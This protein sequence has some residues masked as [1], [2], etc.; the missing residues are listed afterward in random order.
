M[1]AAHAGR[2]HPDPAEPRG[3]VGRAGRGWRDGPRRPLGERRSHLARARV[4]EPARGEEAPRATGLRADRAAL[5]LP[6]VPGAGVDGPGSARRGEAQVL[7]LHPAP[8]IRSAGGARD[9][10]RSGA[11]RDRACA[12]RRPPDRGRAD[13]ALR[14]A[15]PRS[16][17]GHARRRRRAARRAGRR[18]GDVRRQPEHQLHERLRRRLRVLRLRPGPPLAGR[19]RGDR[20]RVP[21]P[22][23][24]S[25][26][27]RSNRDLHAGRH[28]PRLRACRLRP[29]ALA[30]QGSG[31]PAPPPRLLAH[32]GP[33][34]V[35]ALGPHARPGL[36]VSAS[37]RA[38]GPRRAPPPRSWTTG[39]G[40]ASRRTSCPSLAGSRSSRRRT[41]PACARPRP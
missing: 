34:H 3:L 26:R 29:V 11:R 35:R 18:H 4:P 30:R 2:R 36:R 15:P 21:A 40:R 28:P 10:S 9:R 6:A 12:R 13:R 22:H 39:S 8:R 5:R 7:E 27:L 23:R 1:P 17:R 33:L 19:L 38:W 25:G 41:A 14:G 31:S 16:D 32:G 24:R 37:S 20:G